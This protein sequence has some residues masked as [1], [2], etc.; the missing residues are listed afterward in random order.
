M[1]GG[2]DEERPAGE[3]LG[4]HVVKNLF[5]HSLFRKGHILLLIIGIPFGMA[6]LYKHRSRGAAYVIIA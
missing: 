3:P 6:K 4:D 5:S 2:K 1:Y